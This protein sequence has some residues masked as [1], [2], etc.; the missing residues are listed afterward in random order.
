MICI[1]FFGRG[2]GLQD[3][4]SPARDQTWA[5]GSERV[6]SQS[7]DCPGIPKKCMTRTHHYSIIQ[8]S[9]TA[10]KILCVPQ[11]PRIAEAILRKKNE[12]E[13]SGSLTSDLRQSYTNLN[14]TVLSQNRNIDQLKKIESPEIN[15][16]IY[17]HLIYDKGS[18]NIQWR[19]DS[20]FNKWCWEN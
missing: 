20:L 5:L 3:L 8:N 17:G 12:V 15:P 16:H 4:S 9:F 19:E 6:K 2:G 18:K 10:L 13:K 14:N 1:Y 7:Q 11:R